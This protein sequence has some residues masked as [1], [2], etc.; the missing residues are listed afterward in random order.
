[1]C[2]GIPGRITEITDVGQQRAAVMVEGVRRE[3]SVAMIGLDGP[4]GAR[5]D[6]WVIVHLGFAMAKMDEAEAKE[7][8]DSLGALSDMY[9]Q[10]LTDRS[11]QEDE[12]RADRAFSQPS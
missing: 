2:L 4:A 1:M 8:L 5:V 7:T 9:E 10:E 3:V 6:D 11:V 12:V